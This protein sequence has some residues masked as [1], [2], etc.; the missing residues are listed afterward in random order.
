VTTAA[1]PPEDGPP[2][3]PAAGAIARRLRQNIQ[4]IAAASTMAMP[5][6]RTNTISSGVSSPP[7][8]D[9]DEAAAG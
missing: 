9:V 5:T 3:G 2:D 1:V 8:P 4:V 6:T 7:D